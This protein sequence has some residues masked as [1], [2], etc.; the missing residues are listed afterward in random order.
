MEIAPGATAEEEDD[1]AHE[2]GGHGALL[3]TEGAQ[4]FRSDARHASMCAAGQAYCNNNEIKAQQREARIDA[5]LGI[6]CACPYQSSTGN[7]STSSTGNGSTNDIDTSTGYS[8]TFEQNVEQLEDFS[9][10]GEEYI[11]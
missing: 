9:N 4:Q 11:Y 3:A 2:A 8:N 6:N 7:G 5:Q 10:Q 1:E